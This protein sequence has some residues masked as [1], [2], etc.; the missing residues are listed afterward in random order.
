MNPDTVIR[1]WLLAC[2]DQ[3]G[4]NHAVDYRL[5]DWKTRPDIMFCT[6]RVAGSKP[7]V[8]GDFDLSTADSYSAV[9]RYGR[10]HQTV[11]E[12]DLY[13]SQNGLYELGAFCIAA[14]SSPVIR[15]YFGANGCAFITP[16]EVSNESTFDD[17]EIEYLHRLTCA[18]YENPEHS[19][20]QTNAVVDDIEFTTYIT[21]LKRNLYLTA[22]S[23]SLTVAG[24]VGLTIA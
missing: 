14:Q 2:G 10:L 15:E 12:I 1:P 13:N 5:S 4:I 7:A 22:E 17:D 18:F 11:V 16:L 20:T 6:Y 19:L 9:R 21:N 3:Y 24:E 8:V 23:G